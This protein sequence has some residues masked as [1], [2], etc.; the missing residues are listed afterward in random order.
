MDSK[1]TRRV[2]YW[3]EYQIQYLLDTIINLFSRLYEIKEKL[4]DLTH[5]R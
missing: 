4:V 3:I 5:D 2:N 1:L